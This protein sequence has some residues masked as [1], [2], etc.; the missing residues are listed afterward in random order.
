MAWL[1]PSSTIQTTKHSERKSTGYVDGYPGKSYLHECIKYIFTSPWWGSCQTEVKSPWYLI[2]IKKKETSEFWQTKLVLRQASSHL[3][4][5]NQTTFMK[6]WSPCLPSMKQVYLHLSQVHPWHCL[7]RRL[8]PVPTH[9]KQLS[10]L[11]LTAS[12][13]YMLY[14]SGPYL[15][16]E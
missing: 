2:N 6:Q 7:L 4:V 12:R 1:S 5:K 3:I 14:S 13:K 11:Q 8:W 16:I 10:Y 15:T 9:G